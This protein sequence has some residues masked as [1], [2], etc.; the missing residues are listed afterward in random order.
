MDATSIMTLRTQDGSGAKAEDPGS[1]KKRKP[2]PEASISARGNLLTAM[3]RLEIEVRALTQTL[4]SSSLGT[5]KKVVSDPEEKVK[6]VPTSANK[7]L[8]EVEKWIQDNEFW[9]ERDGSITLIVGEVAFRV[10]REILVAASSLFEDLF[11]LAKLPPATSDSKDGAQT[12][13]SVHPNMDATWTVSLPGDSSRDWRYVLR[14]LMLS[15][16]SVSHLPRHTNSSLVV[17]NSLHVQAAV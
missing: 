7:K 5:S 4:K 10:R 12:H 15:S 17:S 8:E 9:S 13:I 16:R 2:F 3:D 1:R 11:L 14:K 6:P